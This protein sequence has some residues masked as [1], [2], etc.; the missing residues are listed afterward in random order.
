M[1]YRQ[2]SGLQKTRYIDFL[3]LT[4]SL[5]IRRLKFSSTVSNFDIFIAAFPSDF[6]ILQPL[7]VGVFPPLKHAQPKIPPKSLSQGTLTFTQA[8][9]ITA[10]QAMHDKGF[11]KD[12][13]ISGLEETG[14]FPPSAKSSVVS[15][16][17]QMQ[18]KR[19]APKPSLLPMVASTF[20]M[21]ELLVERDRRL[22]KLSSRRSRGG[23]FQPTG[24][25]HAAANQSQQDNVSRQPSSA[26]T[27]KAQLQ[28]GRRAV[29][30]EMERVKKLWR[31]DQFE[32]LEVRQKRLAFKAW[33]QHTGKQE[34]FSALE[35]RDKEYAL[36]INHKVDHFFADTAGSDQEDI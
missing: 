31:D 29:K 2:S 27:T 8:E 26:R 4:A 5:V 6:H 28:E 24:N 25:S 12:N 14:I 32:R 20:R 17:S 19:E 18:K 30:L 36:L 33:L 3:L 16:F 23:P 11:T 35:T 13:I 15:V 10:F 22:E 21:P 1:K 9:F 7:D 34:E